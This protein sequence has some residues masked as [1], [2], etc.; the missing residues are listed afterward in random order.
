MDSHLGELDIGKLWQSTQDLADKAGLSDVGQAALI[1]AAKS[2][3]KSP[4]VVINRGRAAALTRWGY[5]QLDTFNRHR[6]TIFAISAGLCGMSVALGYR[7]RKVPE[8]LALYSMSAIM[9]GL[10]A[11]LTRPDALRPD[12]TMATVTPDGQVIETEAEGPGTMSQVLGWLDAKHAQLNQESPGWQRA[13][14]RRLANDLGYD[15][16]PSPYN[17]FIPLA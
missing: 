14:W 1:G 5:N 4:A 10:L 6:P 3:A 9:T 8:G 16:I 17:E 11:W 2:A 7:R 13:T 15:T 12:K